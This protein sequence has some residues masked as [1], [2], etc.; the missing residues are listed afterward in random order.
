MSKKITVPKPIKGFG[1][2]STWSDGSLGWETTPF[3]TNSKSR[4]YV[5]PPL[6]ERN[7]SMRGERFF[8]CEITIKPILNKKGR[9]ITK[10][11]PKQ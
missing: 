9:P 5:S 11:I 10:V 8:L 1:Y 3:V 4:K 7:P 2:S 6:P